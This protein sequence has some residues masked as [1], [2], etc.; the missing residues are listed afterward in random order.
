[1]LDSAAPDELASPS[2]EVPLSD[3]GAPELSSASLP[4]LDS[5]SP[6]L[7][8]DSASLAVVLVL[9]DDSEASCRWRTS[10][11]LPSCRRR[12]T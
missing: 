4:V 11:S 6:P 5:P 3:A 10:S 2:P 1:V 7:L 8:D 12:S 9:V